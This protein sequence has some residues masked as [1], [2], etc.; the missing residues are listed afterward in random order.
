[1]FSR[2]TVA[3]YVVWGPTDV[4]ETAGAM[5]IVGTDL[6]NGKRPEDGIR[7]NIRI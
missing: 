5:R 6:Y 1:M 3:G 7:G 4:S 2:H